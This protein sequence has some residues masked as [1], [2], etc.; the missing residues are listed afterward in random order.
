M[1]RQIYFR[2]QAGP[3]SV[4]LSQMPNVSHVPQIH[5]EGAE[6]VKGLADL[7]ATL[8]KAY[9]R[10]DD[11]RQ[12]SLIEDAYLDART[13]MAKWSA[14]YQR[15]NQGR[16]ALEA[17]QAY[18]QQWATIAQDI[19][20]RYGDK[21]SG[22]AQHYLGRKLELGRL[23]A[24][25]DGARWQKQQTNVW[26]DNQDKVGLALLNADITA[27]PY[28]D[29]RHDM[30]ERE[31]LQAWQQ[32][33]PGQDATVQRLFLQ[34]VRAESQIESM[35]ARRDWRAVETL[36]GR[37]GN[38]GTGDYRGMGS[39]AVAHESGG[40]PG[41]I[42]QDTQGS[43]SYGLFQ[44]NNMGGK[45]T[46]NSFMAGL[47]TSH[48]KLY[49]A[50]G[51]GKYAV[52][53]AGF[54]KLFQETAR[55]PMRAEM[56]QA[57]QEHLG[58]Q[59]VAPVE[60]KLKGSELSNVFGDNRAYKE[61]MLST[62]I[63]HGPGGANRIMREAW[64]M[65]DKNAD[66]QA[67]LEQFIKATYQLRGR[68]G[69]FRTALSE[70]KDD[71][72]RQQ[73][74]NSMRGRYAK[75]EAQALAMAGGVQLGG[76]IL[77]PEKEMA[78]RSKY[79][80]LRREE[81]EQAGLTA[82]SLKN[83]IAFGM[84]SGDFSHVEA[85]MRALSALG[86]HEDAAKAAQ[87]V[88]LARTAYDAMAGVGDLPL[89]EQGKAAKKK[90]GEL[91][92]PDNAKAAITMRDH[93][94]KAAEARQ[95]AFIADPAAYVAALPAMQGRMFPQERIARSLELQ[96]RM[97]KGLVFT[98]AILGKDQAKQLKQG[99]DDLKEPLQRAQW[100]RQ[101]N[102]EYGEYTP[103]VLREMKVP[104]QVN[105]LRPVMDHLS[106]KNL[107]TFMHAIEVK[108]G[109]ISGDQDWKKE[110]QDVTANSEVLKATQDLARAF[111]GNAAMRAY[112][113][114][115]QETYGKFVLLGGKAEELEGA[116]DVHNGDNC[117]LLMS[118]NSKY[119]AADVADA[120]NIK[121]EQL[122]EVL[123]KEISNPTSQAGRMAR[124]N[125]MATYNNGVFVTDETG[126]NVILL[127]VQTGHPVSHKGQI[128]QFTIEDL[129]RGHTPQHKI[130]FGE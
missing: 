80:R 5:S 15:N 40:D 123:L 67:Q 101:L 28:D 110:A 46:A 24:I 50:L 35:L 70:K 51:G 109:D 99:Y 106:D 33:H 130:Q 125:L 124:I 111:P 13:Q 65:V 55:G 61:V 62:A 29:A 79:E 74:M 4:N 128:V 9:V 95:K 119:T 26:Y 21:L 19:N 102:A 78:L 113:D 59:Y 68:P 48:P 7:G 115:L 82:E 56:I 3:A 91:V 34:Q 53:S 77:Q 38:G 129:A 93:V 17:Q 96:N 76:G 20:Q 10:W 49:E 69:E 81:K 89:M 41:N 108:P 64:G 11:K 114:K 73:F 94:S 75:E 105:L 97:G 42:S 98:P 87:Q 39:L 83:H 127:D 47:K 63:Q 18:E 31:Y 112:A 37:Y 8:G 14:E 118:K 117:Y 60:A 6:I 27:N 100:L 52:G 122:L 25:D 32:R 85:D 107:G 121:R 66:K 23:Y 92:T 36:L 71:A 120:A 43:K 88:Q 84:D 90:V 22:G 116:F 45:G 2:S 54:D 57:Q 72:A 104:D 12:A 58:A 30:N 103:A 126:N 44:F 86:F 16:D 1:A